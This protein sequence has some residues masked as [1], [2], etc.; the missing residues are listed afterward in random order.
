MTKPR[1]IAVDG[2]AASGKG[3]LAAKLAAH[4]NLP[5]LD[6]GALYRG[7]ALAVLRAGVDPAN[8]TECARLA[9]A[10]DTT[11]LDDDAL[12]TEEVGQTASVISAHPQVRAALLQLQRDFAAQ[13]GGA[14]LDGR[15]IGTVIC[16]DASAKFFVEASVDVRAK[17][18]FLQLQARGETVDYEKVLTDLAAR[19][20]RDMQRTTA[21]LL[22]A[23]DAITLHTDAMNADE[24]LAAALAQLRR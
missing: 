6:T 23:A 19:D 24:V 9:A 2:P 3:T 12:R 21:P 4:F 13:P 16:P 8:E 18:R 17:R 5:H 7:T 10:L 15:D 20:A 1:V 14:V 11:A 22:A